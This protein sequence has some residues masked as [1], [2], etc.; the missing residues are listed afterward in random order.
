MDLHIL[1]S[2]I[3]NIKTMLESIK[4][5]SKEHFT[6]KE[7][8]KYLGISDSTLYKLTSS[9]SITYYQPNGKLIYFSKSDL[10]NFIY[11]VR[12]KT[13]DEIKEEAQER[14]KNLKHF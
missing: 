8:S 3:Q 6:I 9:N 4:V 2:E 5:S 10:D 12:K 13:H 1:F 7:A 11:K 14:I